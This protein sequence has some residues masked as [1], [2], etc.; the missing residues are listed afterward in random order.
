VLIFSPL[1]VSQVVKRFMRNAALS[2]SAAGASACF[3]ATVGKKPTLADSYLHQTDD[4]F[5][6]KA[7]P[8][9]LSFGS[10]RFISFLLACILLFVCLQHM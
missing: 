5:E 3:T 6:Y 10:F 4:V 8:F 9:S 2:S 7:S 1:V